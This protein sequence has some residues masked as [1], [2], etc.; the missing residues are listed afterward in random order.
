[1]LHTYVLH[2]VYIFIP[3]TKLDSRSQLVCVGVLKLEYLAAARHFG[4]GQP[5]SPPFGL[6][7]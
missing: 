3:T 2:K 5:V 4:S 1:M 6:V 7:P